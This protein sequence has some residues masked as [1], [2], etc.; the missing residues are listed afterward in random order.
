MIQEKLMYKKWK[1]LT[2][3]QKEEAQKRLI[4]GQ[5]KEKCRFGFNSEGELKLILDLL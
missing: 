1:S 4:K 5:K 3:K 2:L